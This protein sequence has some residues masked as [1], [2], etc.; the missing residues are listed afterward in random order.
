VRSK[1]LAA[2]RAERHTVLDF[3]A[4]LSPD[5]WAA[6]S[7]AD[8][9]T[10]RDVVAHMTAGMQALVTPAAIA[11]MTTRDIER[12]NE[13]AVDKC[14][15]LTPEQVLDGFTTWTKRGI[16][17]L[18]AFTA[19]GV[20]RLPL[21]VGELGIYPL[22]VFPA[23]YTFD[24]HTHLRHDIAPA[25]GRPAPPTDNQRMAA[26]LCWL[27]ALLQQSHRARLAWLDTPVSLTLDGPGGGT[28]CIEPAA[29]SVLR[30]QRDADDGAT[31][32]ITAQAL[33]FPV[34]ST[35]RMWWRDCDV[36]ITGDSDIGERLLD[37]VNLV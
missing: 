24:W 23:M 29:T 10:V 31:T 2:L 35:T 18:A 37:T 34:W 1:S 19:P 12:F 8:G 26:I 13:R 28:W 20:G 5:E 16:V 17:G 25:I 7:R 11:A 22:N 9:W 30:I 6:P 3:C 21:P 15:S 32:K 27:I 4:S 36:E 14:R 33:E